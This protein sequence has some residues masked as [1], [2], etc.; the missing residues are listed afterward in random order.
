MAIHVISKVAY[1]VI[2]EIVK[3]VIEVLVEINIATLD[4]LCYQDVDSNFIVIVCNVD[5]AMDSLVQRVSAIDQ[6]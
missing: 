1:V 3:Q 2:M 4:F 5:V 6:N